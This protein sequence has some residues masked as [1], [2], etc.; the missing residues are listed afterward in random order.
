M[1]AQRESSGYRLYSPD[2]VQWI[3]YLHRYMRDAQVS[4]RQLA[5]ILGWLP[6]KEIRARLLGEACHIAAPKGICWHG[7]H[8]PVRSRI[9]R[10]CP[11]YQHK[12]LALDFERIFEAR[13]RERFP[14]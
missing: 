9:C 1:L 3:R 4:P 10:A 7:N 8:D 5:R 11:T 13:L 12:D 6:L 2:D 14:N